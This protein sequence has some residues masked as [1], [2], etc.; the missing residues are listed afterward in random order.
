MSTPIEFW[1]DPACPFCWATARWAVDEVAPHRDLDIQWRPISLLRKNNP[2]EGSEYRTVSEH[3]HKTLRMMESVR[4][5]DGND[6]VFKLYWEAASRIHHDKEYM[7]DPA[8][9]L[10]AAGLDEQHLAAY[11]DESWD[12]VI[13]EKMDDG[14]SLVGNDVGT[15]IIAKLNSRGERVGYF[16][17]VITKIPPTDDSLKLW[18]ALDAMMDIDGFFELKKT[19][20]EAPDPGPRPS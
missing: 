5:T 2:P 15:P 11:D 10:A 19:R 14:L 3:T 18:D 6:G 7:Y 8:E 17:P 9:V 4:T 13:A 1:V 12:D 16:G 20:T